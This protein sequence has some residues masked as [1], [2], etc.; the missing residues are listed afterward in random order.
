MA[1]LAL[2]GQGKI[3]D[4]KLGGTAKYGQFAGIEV[5]ASALI[6]IDP[7]PAHGIDPVTT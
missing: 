6:R 1:H 3:L 2:D 4:P 7:L 5:L